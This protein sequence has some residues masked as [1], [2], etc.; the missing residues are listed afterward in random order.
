MEASPQPSRLLQV[1]GPDTNSILEPS[2]IK[3]YKD[4]GADLGM[5]VMFT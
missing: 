4:V 2:S 3:D 1:M 5:K